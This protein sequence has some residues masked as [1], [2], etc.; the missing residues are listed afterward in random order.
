MADCER[1]VKTL[2][3]AVLCLERKIDAIKSAQAISS[4]SAGVIK[5]GC[6]KEGPS[7]GVNFS[8]SYEQAPHGVCTVS[9]VQRLNARPIIVVSGNG[10]G[11][12]AVVPVLENVTE[13]C[14]QVRG[15]DL[16][17]RGGPAALGF[18]F[19]VLSPQPK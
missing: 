13:S 17:N 15:A 16:L 4:V 3:D 14:F 5:E 8:T 1:G 19:L 9:L 18:T 11:N 2:E 10:G 7:I 12:G 6:T